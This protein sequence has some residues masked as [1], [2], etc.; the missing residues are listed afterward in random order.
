[1]NPAQARKR[2]EQL[3][4]EI[5]RH[6][7]LYYVEATPDISDREY[8]KLYDEL[9]AIEAEYPDLITPTSPTQRVG[10]A[11]IEGFA[12]VQHRAPMLSLEKKED[13]RGA[14]TV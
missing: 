11:P 13:Q 8:D 12:R 10:G 1:M 2:A 4:A 9:K 6:N 7:R 5:E 3:R 14:R